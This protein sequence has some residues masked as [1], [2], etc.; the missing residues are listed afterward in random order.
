MSRPPRPPFPLTLLWFWFLRILPAWLGIA[1]I[2]FLMQIAVAAIVH[3]NA[4]VRTFLAF[5][6]L[7]PSIVKTAL[8]RHAAIREHVGPVDHRVP[9]SVRH[10]PVYAVRRGVPTGLLTGEVQRGRWS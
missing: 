6:N 1:A 9:A 10:V 8:G 7:L 2:I 4:N 3:D 5:I